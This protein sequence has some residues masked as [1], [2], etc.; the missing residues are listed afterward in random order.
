MLDGDYVEAI[1][2]R[3]TLRG[4]AKDWET[5]YQTVQ[6]EREKDVR[7]TKKALREKKAMYTS[8]DAYMLRSTGS[9]ITLTS[10][11]SSTS[12]DFS[13]GDKVNYTQLCSLWGKHHLKQDFCK[14][15]RFLKLNNFEF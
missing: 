12:G 3:D 7:D 6:Y 1:K 10:T 4:E 15:G 14:S 8:V 9:G 11:A 5:K 13:R 2:Y